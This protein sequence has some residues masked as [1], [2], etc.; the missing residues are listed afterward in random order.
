MKPSLHLKLKEI[1]T[2]KESNKKLSKWESIANISLLQIFSIQ[3]VTPSVVIIFK[4]CGK[5]SVVLATFE[6]CIKEKAEE[7]FQNLHKPG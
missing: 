5:W 7:D 2:F 1:L 4:G 3:K 6:N